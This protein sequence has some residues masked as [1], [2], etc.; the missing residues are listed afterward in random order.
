MA[1][2]DTY[3]WW[4]TA[5]QRFLR[6]PRHTRWLQ[7][8]AGDKVLLEGS[9]NASDWGTLGSTSGYP[10]TAATVDASTNEAPVQ[11][12]RLNGV[13]LSTGVAYQGVICAG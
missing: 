4:S 9:L 11:F 1:P 13:A 6:M 7:P 10:S 3:V 5:T 2:R 12:V 8:A